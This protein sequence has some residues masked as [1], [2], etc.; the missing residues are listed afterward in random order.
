MES[1]FQSGSIY[2]TTSASVAG[3]GGSAPIGG[4]PVHPMAMGAGVGGYPMPAMAMGGG[5]FSPAMLMAMQQQQAMMQAMAAQA[6]AQRVAAMAAAAP[7]MPVAHSAAAVAP[8]RAAG[9]NLR[10]VCNKGDHASAKH[11][12]KCSLSH[13]P[14]CRY[15]SSCA[16]ADCSFNHCVHMQKAAKTAGPKLCRDGKACTRSDC[17]FSH[18]EG[19]APAKARGGAGGGGSRGPVGGGV[20][21]PAKGP[22]KPYIAPVASAAATT[23]TFNPEVAAI[24][25]AAAAAQLPPAPKAE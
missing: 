8:V 24:L 5:G 12:E 6:Y 3:A 9:E 14:D 25:A 4:Y 23:S 21:S 19:K 16:R 22:G 15:G 18:P 2:P 7:P 17:H 11:R 20:R 10:H 1:N 13:T